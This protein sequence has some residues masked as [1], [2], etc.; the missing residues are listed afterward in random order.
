LPQWKVKENKEKDIGSHM[1]YGRTFLASTSA[2]NYTVF[3]RIADDVEDPLKDVLPGDCE[4]I[5]NLHLEIYVPPPKSKIGMLC[6]FM[7][8][9]GGLYGDLKASLVTSFHHEIITG[10]NVTA[11]MKARLGVGV[12]SRCDADIDDV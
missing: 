4:V 5:T 8:P 2:F 1:A 11:A 6:N 3:V 10:N 12:M 9:R 7:A